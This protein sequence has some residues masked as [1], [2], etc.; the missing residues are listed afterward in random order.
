[1]EMRKCSKCK[2]EKNLNEHNFKIKIIGELGF[3]KNCKNCIKV[4]KKY[5]DSNKEELLKKNKE[6]RDPIKKK[7]WEEKNKHKRKEQSKEWRKNNLDKIK[8]NN[9]KLSCIKHKKIYCMACD[10][11]R[12]KTIK[13]NLISRMS[14]IFKKRNMIWEPSKFNLYIGCNNLEL[15]EYLNLL[16]K[17]RKFSW[18]NY[19][20]KSKNWQIDHIKPLDPNINITDNE[21]IKRLHYKNLQP[22]TVNENRNK[23][24]TEIYKL[25]NLFNKIL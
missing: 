23:S 6:N 21:F 4:C 11:H 10:T 25:D 19:G 16:I 12:E 7:E 18:D 15:L 1:M 3:T 2:K 13:N 20:C 8:K 24:N 17:K 5:Y 14:Q 9:E 22:L